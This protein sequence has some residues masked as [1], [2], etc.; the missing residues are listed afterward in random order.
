MATPSQ[1]NAADVRREQVREQLWPGSS[2]EIFDR[3]KHDGY[4]TVPRIL[5]LILGLIED[6]ADKGKNSSRV[7]CELWFRCFDDKLVEVK[8]ENEIAYASGVTV[9]RWKERIA[10]LEKLGFVRTRPAGRLTYGYILLRNPYTVVKELIDAGKVQD[11]NWLGAYTRRAA[12]IG[13]K[14]P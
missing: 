6:L 2:N 10:E 5:S 13:Y 8:D 11:A 14:L 1:P 12:E 4:S 7:Y 9:R 3:K